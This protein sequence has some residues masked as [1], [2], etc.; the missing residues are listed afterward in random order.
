LLGTPFPIAQGITNQG[1]NSINL[2]VPDGYSFYVLTFV[3]GQYKFYSLDSGLGGS[4][5]TDQNDAAS[6]YPGAP[7]I[8]PGQGFFYVNNAVTTVNWSQIFTLTP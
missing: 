8:S 5:W 2:P 7:V 4:G 1:P 3:G 6:V